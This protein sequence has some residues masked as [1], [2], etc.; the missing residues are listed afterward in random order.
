MYKFLT[1]AL[2]NYKNE[3]KNLIEQ[4]SLNYFEN[5][6]D[7]F[8]IMDIINSSFL[9]SIDVKQEEKVVKLN[10]NLSK[11]FMMSQIRISLTEFQKNQIETLTK[12][13]DS[14]TDMESKLA[15]HLRPLNMIK[16]IEY[17][18]LNNKISTNQLNP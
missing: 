6:R 14:Q 17:N 7:H 8:I 18:Y 4:Q 2:L 10:D 16:N 5:K 12:L 9:S 3:I 15:Y 13:Y 11:I 1:I